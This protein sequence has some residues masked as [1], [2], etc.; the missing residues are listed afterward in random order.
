LSNYYLLYK[1]DAGLQRYDKNA[2][3][4]ERKKERKEDRKKERKKEP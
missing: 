4:K 2:D 3:K 1:K